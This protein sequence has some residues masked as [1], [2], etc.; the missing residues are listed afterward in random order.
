MIALANYDGI[1]LKTLEKA[2]RFAFSDHT[3]LAVRRQ[4]EFFQSGA[5]S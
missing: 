3:S 4:P 2:F 1:G 5:S